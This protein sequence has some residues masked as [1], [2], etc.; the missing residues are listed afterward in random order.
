MREDCPLSYPVLGMNFAERLRLLS[1]IRRFHPECLSTLN[2]ESRVLEILEV[3]SFD[4]TKL[5]HDGSSLASI[6]DISREEMSEAIALGKLPMNRLYDIDSSTPHWLQYFQA[7]YNPAKLTDDYPLLTP[8]SP[9]YLATMKGIKSELHDLRQKDYVNRVDLKTLVDC[10]SNQLL[11]Q[12][13]YYC[14]KA[15]V[16]EFTVANRA[17]ALQ[18]SEGSNNFNRFIMH[19]KSEPLSRAFLN[20][21]PVLVNIC[22]SYLSNFRSALIELVQRV[23]SDY[24]E[25]KAKFSPNNDLGGIV[26]Y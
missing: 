19:L 26:K 1:N 25:I 13:S 7:R 24:E 11:E 20:R 12:L 4:N 18:G 16:A 9:L 14:S 17:G 5:Y 10:A 6:F 15:I 3:I 22:S 21:Y 8:V 23:I 2:Q